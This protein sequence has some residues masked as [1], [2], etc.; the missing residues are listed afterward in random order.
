VDWGVKKNELTRYNRG[1]E[2]EKLL[3]GSEESTGGGA[4]HGRVQGIQWLWG[5]SENV[6]WGGGREGQ[7]EWYDAYWVLRGEVG[8]Q[9]IGKK[10]TSRRYSMN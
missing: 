7:T 3:S 4:G 8:S 9:I 10:G 5:E 1:E 2:D 6:N